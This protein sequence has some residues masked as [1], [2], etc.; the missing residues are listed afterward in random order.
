M[1]LLVTGGNGFVM[2][3]LV[4]HWLIANPSAQAIVLDSAPADEIVRNFLSPVAER[5][6]ALTGD[7]AD[8]SAWESALPARDYSYRA[9]GRGY[10]A[11]LC[12]R[13]R[14]GPRSRT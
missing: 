12:R 1:T 11:S 5:V 4:R 14:H 10:A 8:P 7:V 6:V 9:R 3:H 13:G 2:S